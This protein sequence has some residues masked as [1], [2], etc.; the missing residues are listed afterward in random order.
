MVAWAPIRVGYDCTRTI[1]P[2]TS[3]LVR[4]IQVKLTSVRLPVKHQAHLSPPVARV[5]VRT[6]PS[7][8]SWGHALRVI[9]IF[10]C[11][12]TRSRPTSCIN[13]NASGL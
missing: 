6:G 8:F 1:R 12:G 5:L 9:I 2:L 7:V 4:G 11:S 3:A 13:H 10:I